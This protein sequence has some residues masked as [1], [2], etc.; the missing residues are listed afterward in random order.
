MRPLRDHVIFVA[1]FVAVN[2]VVNPSDIRA[3]QREPSGYGVTSRPKARPFGKSSGTKSEGGTG[4]TNVP[5]DLLVSGNRLLPIVNGNA[6]L[7]ACI[8]S[9][10]RRNCRVRKWNVFYFQSG[11]QVKF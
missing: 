2:G 1:R 8:P 9:V 6:L 7:R 4:A 5:E 11:K 3:S 10:M